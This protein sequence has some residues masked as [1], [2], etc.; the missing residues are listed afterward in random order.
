MITVGLNLVFLVP[1]ETGG[2][3]VYAR[4]LVA[5]LAERPGLR[6]VAFVSR[7]GA[8][9]SG[10]PWIDGVRA[11][12]LPVRSR[13]RAE[14]VLGEQLQLPRLAAAEGCSV[15]HS[16]AS[17]AP[18][19]CRGRRVTTIHDLNYKLM[20]EAHFGLRGLGM[21][22]LVP[23]AARRSHRIITGAEAAKRDLVAH[24]GTPPDRIDVVP[25]GVAANPQVAATPE[26]ELRSRLGLGQRRVLLSVS[27]KRPHKNLARLLDALAGIA[28]GRRPMLVLPGYP[29]PH[30]A[31]LR[32]RAAALGLTDDIVFL[33]WI[34]SEDLEGLYRLSIGFV[35]PSLLEGFGLPVLEAMARGVP[36][37]SSARGAVGE[38]AGGAALTFD[39]EDTGAIRAAIERLLGDRRE[40]DRL[41]EAGRQRARDFTWERTAQLTHASYRRALGG[42]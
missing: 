40:T 27:A 17:T 41:R 25:H 10:A 15:V 36:V 13:H 18:L 5:R 26:A 28:T 7:E 42:P 32:Q 3:E 35:F 37:A 2:M 4:E 21:R 31:E 14:W 11:R 34:A 33:G 6:L 8:G 38:V 9:A 12:T 30:E 23:A 19:W 29:T 16:L 24:L 22:A 20:P 1:G 39:P